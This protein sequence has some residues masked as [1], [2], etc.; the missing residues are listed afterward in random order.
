MTHENR[1]AAVLQE[2]PLLQEAALL[3]YV[4][5]LDGAVVQQETAALQAVALE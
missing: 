3:R 4:R 1:K 5:E 2:A